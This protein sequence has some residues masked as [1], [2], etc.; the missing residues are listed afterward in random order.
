MSKDADGEFAITLVEVA[1]QAQ[2]HFGM[3]AQTQS[4]VEHALNS[5]GIGWRQS[6]IVTK[7]AKTLGALLR[8]D[9][10][11]VSFAVLNFTVSSN[12][13]ALSGSLMG[14]FLRHDFLLIRWVAQRDTKKLRQVYGF[15]NS[16]GTQGDKL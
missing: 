9:V 10:R 11:A 4:G 12:L 1:R 8:Q 7:T 14:L 5:L 3:K 6:T 13:E 2:E 15:F 16:L